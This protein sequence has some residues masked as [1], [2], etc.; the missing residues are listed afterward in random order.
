MLIL[1]P[2]AFILNFDDKIYQTCGACSPWKPDEDH[3]LQPR[4]WNGLIVTC[5]PPFA[6]VALAGKP[7]WMLPCVT[8]SNCPQQR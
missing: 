8:G 3:Q 4:E 1:W 6:Q 7:A 2:V 5:W